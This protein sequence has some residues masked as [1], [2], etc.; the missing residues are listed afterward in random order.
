MKTAANIISVAKA[1]Y[2]VAIM[3]VLGVFAFVSAVLIAWPAL[4]YLG[5]KLFN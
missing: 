2:T 3:T 4:A 5:S 1:S